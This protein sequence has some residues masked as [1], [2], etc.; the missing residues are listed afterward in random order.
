MPCQTAISF[1][2]ARKATPSPATFL[3][4][5]L[6]SLTCSAPQ[7]PSCTAKVHFWILLFLLCQT[8][9]WPD[10]IWPILHCWLIMKNCTLLPR[11]IFVFV[12]FFLDAMPN[13]MPNNMPWQDL[14]QLADCWC[15]F[16]PCKRSTPSTAAQVNCFAF[17][18]KYS[19]WLLLFSFLPARKVPQQ[20]LPRLTILLFKNK[21]FL[22]WCQGFLFL[23]FFKCH[24]WFMVGFS[25][26]PARKVP[27]TKAIFST[28]HK[29]HH[30]SRSGHCLLILGV[31]FHKK[32]TPFEASCHS[33]PGQ[34]CSTG[35]LPLFLF[36][37]NIAPHCP[38]CFFV[39]VIFFFDAQTTWS[40]WLLVFYYFP[41]RKVTPSPMSRSFFR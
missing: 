41:T 7:H 28:I 18:I 36:S 34:H 25:F 8:T 1:F 16:S 33:K 10:K 21:I 17:K 27:A 38:S 11:L 15:S 3:E 26:F 39:F 31:S 32:S 13:N 12:I 6:L 5:T 37:A 35:W 30:L 40:Y 23:L 22:F 20:L 24:Q 19:G 9:P 4:I 29:Q 14:G 2:P